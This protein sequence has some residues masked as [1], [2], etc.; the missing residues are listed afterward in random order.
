MPHELSDCAVDAKSRKIT[1]GGLASEAKVPGSTV[2][3]R[4]SPFSSV[5]VGFSRFPAFFCVKRRSL[6]NAEFRHH[7]AA[8][9]RGGVTGG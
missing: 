3:E 5:L 2:F 6:A 8:L 1:A 9:P 7:P 4:F